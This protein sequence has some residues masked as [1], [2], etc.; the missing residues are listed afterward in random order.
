MPT[1][2][3]APAPTHANKRLLARLRSTASSLPG[4][5][6]AFELTRRDRQRA[7][8]VLAAG[9]GARTFLMLLP[10]AFIV[11][12]VVGFLDETSPGFSTRE[13]RAAGLT[14]NLVRVVAQ[15]SGD[16]RRGRWVFLAVGVVLL[17]YA[18]YSL[19]RALFM[20]HLVAWGMTSARIRIG[21]VVLVCVLLVLLPVFGGVASLAR[22]APPGLLIALVLPAGLVMYSSL[23][24]W[25]SWLLP[26]R[27]DRWTGLVPGALAWGGGMLVLQCISVLVLPDRVGGLSQ[28]Y[29]TLA[30]ASSAMAWLFILGR[31]TVGAATLNA[32][33]WDRRH[34]A[35]TTSKT[36]PA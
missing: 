24:L 2:L 26:H 11:A 27:A 31:L 16:A 18:A 6:Q 7:G 36:S 13:V 33:L 20:T 22:E 4:S 3:S 29:G 23:W 14:A 8:S 17:F 15:S 12:A 32:V 19:F 28:L 21:S 10:L 5:T 9:I 35:I 34:Q 1:L 25:V 30:V